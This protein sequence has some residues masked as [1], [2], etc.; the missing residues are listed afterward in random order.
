MST[1]AEI[2]SR[3]RS[4][5]GTLENPAGSNNVVFNTDYYG[6]AVS[7]SAYPWCCA[8]LWD[9]FRMGGASDL[10]YDGQRTAYCPALMSWGRKKGLEVKTADI[11]AGDIVFFDW[12]GNK[13]PDH[14][15]LAT[16]AISNGKFPTVEGNI[17]N[18]VC[19][20]T[21]QPGQVCCVLRPK[22]APAESNSD[23]LGRIRKLII[24]AKDI[25]KILEV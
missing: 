23:L 22:Y 3:A 9:V 11:R 13:D 18:A 10:F 19:A 6:H 14:V 4:Y 24:E 8:F 21:R 25:I 20:M 1:A 17:N 7:G 12:N 5:I 15:G 16:G 2:V